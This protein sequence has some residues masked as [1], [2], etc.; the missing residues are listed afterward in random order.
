MEISPGG[1]MRWSRSAVSLI[2]GIT[3]FGCSDSTGPAPIT[4]TYLLTGYNGQ[5]VPTGV[6]AGGGCTQNILDGSFV[7]A[8]DHTWQAALTVEM[9]CV[10]DT[11]TAVPVTIRYHGSYQREAAG[12]HLW[13]A[14]SPPEDLGLAATDGQKLQVDLRPFFGA[15]TEYQRAP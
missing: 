15:L 8:G 13:I 9:N 5:P 2:A 3:L 6:T 1:A 10:G 4:G 7:M 12:I 11:T 14:T